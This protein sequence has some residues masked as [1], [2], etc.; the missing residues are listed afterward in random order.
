MLKES[1]FRS[2]LSGGQLH[3]PVGLSKLERRTLSSV[4]VCNE[5]AINALLLWMQTKV[6]AP[7]DKKERPPQNDS[8]TGLQSHREKKG[9]RQKT[10][11][12]EKKVDEEG[13]ISNVGSLLAEADRECATPDEGR[14]L[15]VLA[16]SDV[17]QTF[18][19]EQ[20]KPRNFKEKLNLF[21]LHCHWRSSKT[22]DLFW[23]RFKEIMNKFFEM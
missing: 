23:F 19:R 22:L 6:A 13:R 9:R 11:L 10:W 12:W 1:I 16:C 18:L 7:L 17:I 2:T 3:R 5:S 14:L 20:M 21:H 15:E 4:R 8:K